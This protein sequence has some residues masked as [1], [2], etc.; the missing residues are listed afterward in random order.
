MVSGEM[1]GRLWRLG[2]TL[3]GGYLA[4]N[5]QVAARPASTLNSLDDYL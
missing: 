4:K 1:S 5:A 2:A 3:E